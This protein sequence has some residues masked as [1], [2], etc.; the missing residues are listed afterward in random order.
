MIISFKDIGFD[1]YGNAERPVLK[2]KTLGGKVITTI[3]NYIGLSPTFRFNDV[4]E[5]TFDVPV[6]GANGVAT[7]NYD[8][9]TGN[10]LIEIGGF[11]DFLLISADETGNGI[12]KRK[13][14][15]AYSLEYNFNFKK[16]YIPDGT[17]CFWNPASSNDT[18]LS[19]I[20]EKMPDWSVGTVDAALIGRYRTFDTVESNVY[21]FMMNTL[22]TTYN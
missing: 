3:G 20:L 10:K 6:V 7:P 22:Q 17:Y 13:S 14:C 5:F 1:A 11:G 12:E 15:K 2:L 9:I 4:S 16:I 18:I 21:E 19:I 8:R